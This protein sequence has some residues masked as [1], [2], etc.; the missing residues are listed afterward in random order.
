MTAVGPGAVEILFRHAREAPGTGGEDSR[1]GL[2]IG[3]GEAAIEYIDPARLLATGESFDMVIVDEAAA[4]PLHRLER[5]LERFPRLAFASTVH[6]YEGSGRGF[7]TR[8][9]TLL[10]R[11]S[12]GWRTVNLEQP[13]RWAAGDPVE[14]TVADMLLLDAEAADIAQPAPCTDRDCEVEFLDRERLGGD[15]A[16]LRQF[17]GLLVDAHYRTR[18]SDLRFLLDDPAL[19][20]VCA[21]ARGLVI[22][23]AVA[24]IEDHC[25][26]NSRGR[27]R[28][29][30][31]GRAATSSPRPSRP[32]SARAAGSSFAECAWFASPFTR[33]C[34]GAGSE[35]ASSLRSSTAPGCGASTTSAAVLPRARTCWT[36]GPRAASR[37]RGSAR[38]ATSPAARARCWP[39][40]R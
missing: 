7:A 38:G 28:E 9:R 33:A 18:P 26:P 23:A 30:G 5:L 14:R 22:A 15:E 32:S 2:R 25:P 1:R 10:D 12:R 29:G 13:V 27:V 19:E 39:A 35:R 11:H 37:R 40:A 17:F 34:A 31:R 8:F 6:G 24:V 21:R 4:L 20:L 36:S 16:L 3:V